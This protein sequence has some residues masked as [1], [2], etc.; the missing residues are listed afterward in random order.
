MLTRD[1]A[2]NGWGFPGGDVFNADGLLVQT[3]GAGSDWG[4]IWY[5]RHGNLRDFEMRGEMRIE[6]PV[7]ECLLLFRANVLETSWETGSH[8][9]FHLAGRRLGWLYRSGPDDTDTIA[10]APAG[11][12]ARLRV[13]TWNRLAVRCEGRRIRIWLADELAIDFTDAAPNVCLQGPLSFLLRG[14]AAG[15]QRTTRFRDL[16]IQLLDTPATTTPKPMAWTMGQ[17]NLPPIA[18]LL[19]KPQ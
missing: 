7:D 1:T 15:P 2:L 12:L 4:S 14:S 5:G 11:L 18:P 6:G 16:R 13:D 3:I 9:R 19:E 17:Q 8:Y 10:V